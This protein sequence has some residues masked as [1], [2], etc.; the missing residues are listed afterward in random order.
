MLLYVI[1]YERGKNICYLYSVGVLMSLLFSMLLTKKDKYEHN[2]NACHV[3]RLT[4]S[5]EGCED[6]HV[7][8]ADEDGG[9]E[10]ARHEVQGG[11][12]EGG[13]RGAQVLLGQR[14]L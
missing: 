2:N 10:A 14:H 7:V 13:V 11:H 12:V 1:V 3:P 4:C 6:G 9:R 8:A 5:R